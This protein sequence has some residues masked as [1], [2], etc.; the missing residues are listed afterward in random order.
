[1]GAAAVGVQA[2]GAGLGAYSSW[3]QGLAQ[4]SYYKSAA[5]NSRQE[6]AM[7]E[8]EG[9]LESGQAQDEALLKSEQLR[10]SVATLEGQQTAAEGASGTAGSVT[11]AD[12]SNDTQRKSNLDQMMVRY[13]ADRAS[14]Q[15]KTQA[16]LKAWSLNKQADQDEAAGEESRQAGKIGVATSLLGGAGQVAGSWYKLNRTAPSG[17]GSFT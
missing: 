16:A 11:A 3:K 15:A 7:A 17:G 12:I 14:W 13:N 6:A 9:D 1:M 4:Q 8:K 10:R 5:D 2:A